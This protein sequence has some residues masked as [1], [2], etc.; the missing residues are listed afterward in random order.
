VTCPVLPPYRFEP[1]QST[2]FGRVVGDAI[3]PHPPD[4]AH[5]GTTEDADGMRVVTI[6]GPLPPVL[7]VLGPGMAMAGSV[8]E[9]ADGV[10]EAVVAGPSEGCHLAFA[11]FDRHGAHDRISGQCLPGRVALAAAADL[12]EQ[13]SGGN[14][15]LGVAKERE[16]DLAVGM[17]AHGVGRSGS[18]A[19]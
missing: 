17:S 19:G 7:G 2:V 5:P 14:G 11:G 13:A 4:H 15:R 6:A 12:G 16:E 1:S 18:S 9:G 8:G 3:L 10:S